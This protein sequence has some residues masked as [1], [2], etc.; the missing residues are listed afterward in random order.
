VG[1]SQSADAV[2]IFNASGTLITRVDF[3]AASTGISFDN[4]L[5]LNNVTLTQLSAAGVN[6]AFTSPT[7]EVG[8]PAAVPEPSTYAAILGGLA[9]GVTLLRRTQKANDRA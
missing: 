8:S 5:G 2:N 7:G 1:L 9:L 3:G 6:G 4:A